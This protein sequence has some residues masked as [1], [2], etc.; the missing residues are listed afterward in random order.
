MASTPARRNL[1]I[2]TLQ[3]RC[4]RCRE[5]RV[6][7]AP[8]WN[9]G[10]FSKYNT[11]CPV[12]G[13]AFE[14]EPGFFW[15]AMY[16]SYAFSV[17]IMLVGSF[18]IYYLLNDPGIWTYISIIVALTLLLMPYNFQISRIIWILIFGGE[19]FYEKWKKNN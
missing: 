16:A 13:I 10:R 7:Q 9:L 8:P 2:S 14:R 3:C 4:P 6:F 11:H 18:L 19:K 17:G 12:C 1:L 5:G 15:G